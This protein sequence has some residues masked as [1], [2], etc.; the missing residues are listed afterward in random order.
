MDV[1]TSEAIEQLGQRIDAVELSLRN[2]FRAGFAELEARME[3]GFA[4]S[5]RHIGVMIESLRDDIRILAEGFAR[6]S[7]KRE[8]DR[9]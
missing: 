3:T 9:R 6:L 5:R 1:E 7:A 8:S 2:E 4:E